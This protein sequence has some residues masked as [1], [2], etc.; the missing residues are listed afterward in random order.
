[1]KSYKFLHSSLPILFLSLLFFNCVNLFQKFHLN[2]Q[3]KSTKEGSSKT[4]SFKNWFNL[5]F[6]I[7]I[8]ILLFDGILFHPSTFFWRLREEGSGWNKR[9]N[10]LKVKHGNKGRSKFLEQSDMKK[11][12][13]CTFKN[14]RK[15]DENPLQRW[16]CKKSK[17]VFIYIQITH[18][19][20]RKILIYEG[21]WSVYSVISQCSLCIIK[22]N[23]FMF[24][25]ICDPWREIEEWLGFCY[26]YSLLVI[27]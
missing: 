7:S 2:F 17:L 22:M 18:K 11:S 5:L 25:P 9:E 24:I 15:N 13:E 6:E 26:G 23:E 14:D 3:C 21:D 1:M 20:Y 10:N 19:R 12:S 4:K 27:L 8:I 16:V